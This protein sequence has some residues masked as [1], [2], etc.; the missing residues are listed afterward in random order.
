VSK[1]E[2]L[3]ILVVDD[4]PD[5]LDL[6]YRTFRR[7]FKV[8]TADNGKHALEVLAAEGEV[9][10]II[11]DQRMPEMKGTEFL[12]KT[13]PNFPDTVRI[14]LTGF[15]DVE[16]LVEAINSGQVY[17]YIT[18]PWDPEELKAIVLQATDN[19]RQ[20][21]SKY[22]QLQAVKIQTELMAKIVRVALNSESVDEYLR[23]IAI[24]VGE[25]FRASRCLLQLIKANQLV[26]IQGIY[27][28]GEHGDTTNANWLGQS[29]LVS[30]AIQG[31]KSLVW[32]RSSENASPLEMPEEIQTY[33][34]T[35]VV[36]HGDNSAIISLEWHTNDEPS[37][38]ELESLNVLA[39]QLALVLNLH[40]GH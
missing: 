10:L 9:A 20:Q 40:H 34:L 27:E 25:S 7:E 32:R 11:S 31:G 14:I 1:A 38:E 29:D 4:E 12:S 30:Q 17:K 36:Y 33:A 22:Q 23:V 15:T 6:L 19:Y 39:Q 24:A 18:K 37:M 28:Q 21:K 13:V 8:L 2:K 3:K 35:P 26:D 5:N 16:D